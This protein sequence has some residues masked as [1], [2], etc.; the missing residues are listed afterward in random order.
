MIDGKVHGTDCFEVDSVSLGKCWKLQWGFTK[1]PRVLKP[2]DDC[3]VPAE[4]N[5]VKSLLLTYICFLHF[6]ITLLHFVWIIFSFYREMASPSFIKS[7]IKKRV[8]FS[9]WKWL[10][11]TSVQK[12][13]LALT[14][15][16]PNRVSLNFGSVCSSLF[17]RDRNSTTFWISRAGR[18]CL[19]ASSRVAVYF[20]N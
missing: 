10:P 3:S 20:L 4:N 1:F 16:E 13:P 2:V 9:P 7:G 15:R 12:P 19:N 5:I 6:I 18:L 14:F 8:N 17:R 11:G